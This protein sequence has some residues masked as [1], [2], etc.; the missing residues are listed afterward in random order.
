[1]FLN[2]RD[3]SRQDNKDSMQFFVRTYANGKKDWSPKFLGMNGDARTIAKTLDLLEKK[4]ASVDY[5]FEVFDIPMDLDLY[6]RLAASQ[7]NPEFSKKL[8]KI[9]WRRV[10]VR[11]RFSRAAK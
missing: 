3:A 8:Y 5:A 11:A 7:C 10:A 4:E 6:I 9:N 2:Y 1:M